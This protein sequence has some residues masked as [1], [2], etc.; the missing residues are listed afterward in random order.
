MQSRSRSSRSPSTPPPATSTTPTSAA[1]SSRTH[2]TRPSAPTT[3]SV[4]RTTSVPTSSDSKDRSQRHEQRQGHLRA[5]RRDHLEPG[6]GPGLR[7]GEP[8]G[9]RGRPPVGAISQRASDRLATRSHSSTLQ[10]GLV[11]SFATRLG[12]VTQH[13]TSDTRIDQRPAVAPSGDLVVYESCAQSPSNCD[14]RQ[15]AWNGTAS[16]VVT[17]LRRATRTRARTPTPTVRSSSTTPFRG[18]QKRHLLAARGGGI[19]AV[20]RAFGRAARDP[21]IPAV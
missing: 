8:N 10:A 11:S 7:R 14:I 16:W 5:A 9:R 2:R 21:S 13:V 1:T 15:A 17:S 18:V 3:S 12:G 19:R 4:A 6:P 20:P